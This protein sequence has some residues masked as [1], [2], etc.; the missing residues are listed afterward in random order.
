LKRRIAETVSGAF[1]RAATRHMA[2]IL[3]V[4]AF[5]IVVRGRRIDRRFR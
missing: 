5:V 4:I 3:L 2:R 1:S